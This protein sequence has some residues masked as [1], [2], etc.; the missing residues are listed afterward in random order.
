MEKPVRNVSLLKE[1]IREKIPKIKKRELIIGVV[2]G[3]LIVLLGLAGEFKK[4]PTGKL[5]IVVCDVGQGDSIYIKTPKGRDILVDGGPDDKVLNCLNRHMPF[6][7]KKI[8]MVFLTHPQADHLTGL[9]TVLKRYEI[10]YFF[11]DPENN[12]TKQYEILRNSLIGKTTRNLFTGDKIKTGD[13][14]EIK[15]LWPSR[16]FFANNS[17]YSTLV[18]TLPQKNNRAVLGA[19]TSRDLNDFSLVLE[20]ENKGY[21]ALLMGDAGEAVQREIL[22]AGVELEPVDLLK[23]PHHGSRTGLLL[24]F[25]ERVRPAQSVISVG[26]DNSFGH[27]AKEIIEMLKSIGSKVRRTDMEGEVQI[28]S[29]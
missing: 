25:L 4:F 6:W 24:S 17:D 26:I 22:T 19:K 3:L 15:V 29:D 5:M 1:I 28:I 9:L 16:E 12:N 13:G 2:F 23:V 10:G 11:I 20:I 8:E 18:E 14:V 27:P 21:R 7:D